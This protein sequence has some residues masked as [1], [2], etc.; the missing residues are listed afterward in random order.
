MND[1]GVMADMCC[2]VVLP[3]SLL[4]NG[5]TLND[6]KSSMCSPVPMKIIGDFVAAT[7]Q[8]TTADYLDVQ[9]YGYALWRI[10]TQL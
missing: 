3:R 2:E 5:C 1:T 6:S 4:T 9:M 10:E 7:L 8:T